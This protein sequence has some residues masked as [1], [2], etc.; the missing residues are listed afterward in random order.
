MQTEM[1][2]TR[3][4]T[5]LALG[6]GAGL[7]AALV[8]VLSPNWG[9][10]ENVQVVASVNGAP[11]TREKY[12]SHLTALSTDKK[13]P[14][15]NEDSRYVL[16]RIIE[17][18]LLVQRGV[19]VGLLDS[20]K[21]TRAAMVNAMIGMTTATA[22]ATAPS[23][24]ELI[25]FFEDNIDYFTPTS[26][27]R[28]RQLFVVGEDAEQKTQQAYTL[29]QQ[30]EAFEAVNSKYGKSTALSIP[31]TLLPP[32]KVREY[33][34]PT[35]V[36]FLQDKSAGFIS[37]PQKLETGYRLLQLV[38]KEVGER[39]Q[40]ARVLPQVEAEYV[41]R[42]GDRSLREYLEWL[43]DRADISYPSELPL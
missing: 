21:R 8:S 9:E 42:S 19:E 37:Q 36:Q 43:K 18:E 17:E 32:A 16:E 22:E 28:V 25:S 14:I 33:L 40:L 13:D 3:S 15:T 41:R 10:P 38:D 27:L 6:L 1:D 29:L 24:G 20:D 11:I 30:G 4:L 2:E 35:L 7:L 26:R 34:G 12:L 5:G 23:E 31:D 39:P